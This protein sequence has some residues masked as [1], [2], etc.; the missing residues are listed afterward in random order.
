MAVW[1]ELTLSIS[2][3]P[4]QRTK[5]S[6]GTTTQGFVDYAFP[7]FEADAALIHSRAVLDIQRI[8]DNGSAEGQSRSVHRALRFQ[9]LQLWGAK[10]TVCTADAVLG[11]MQNNRVGLMGFPA[12]TGAGFVFDEIHLYDERMFGTLL[13]FLETMRGAPVLLMTAT[14]PPGR[15]AALQQLFQRLGEN[16]FEVKGPPELE[17]LKR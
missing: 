3:R 2:F 9:G 5:S 15:R 10:V 7:E 16:L 1:S 8:L 14:L 12:L 17:T 6:T 4:S 11:L 13:A